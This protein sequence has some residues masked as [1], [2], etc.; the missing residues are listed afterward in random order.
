M[1]LN[2][3][4]LIYLFGLVIAKL[5]F[6]NE[7]TIRHIR[8]NGLQR[9]E[10]G[11]VYSYLPVKE[12]DLFTDDIGNSII[13][14]LYETGFFKDVRIEEQNKD[15]IIDVNERPII[16]GLDINGDSA[17]DHERL[18]KSLS[19]NG[20][21]NSLIFDQSTLDAAILS[22]KMEYYNRG[23][24]AVQIVPKVTELSRNRVNILIDIN[25]GGNAQIAQ[26][27]F[28]GNKHY[29]EGTLRGMMFLSM[30]N[31]MSWWYKDNQYSS[32]KLS[33]D[34]ETIKSFYLNNG[35]IDFKINSIQVQLSSNKK[36]VSINVNMN[37]GEQYRLGKTVVAG[38]VKDAD[39]G[40]LQRIVT[41][42][43]GQIINQEAL[44]RNADSIKLELGKLGYAF[45]SVTPIPEIVDGNIV[46]YT[47]MVDTGKKVSV[48]NII[49]SGNEKTRDIVIRREMRQQEAAIYNEEAIRRSKERLDSLGFF[50]MTDVSTSPVP[51]TVDQV[52]INVKTEE[53]STG[54][55]NIGAGYAQGQGIILNG[56]ISQ[57]NIF[58]SGKSVSLNASTSSLT[59]SVSLSFTDPYF[60][61]NG[62]S[63]GYDVYTMSQTPYKTGISPYK[64]DN[65]GVKMRTT[66]PLS[67]Y[68][69]TVMSVGFENN[70]VTLIGGFIP[71]RFVQFNEHYGDSVNEVS[72]S[73]GWA[74]NTTDN[75]LWPTRGANYNNTFDVTMPGIGAQYYRVQTAG[76]WF[77]PISQDFVWKTKGEASFIN[78]YGSSSLVPF[79]Q[80]FYEGGINSLRGFYMGSLGPRDTD[81]SSLGGT[82]WL[83][84]TNDLLFPMPFVKQDKTTR[85]N[86]F[87]DAGTLFGGSGFD[88]TPEQMFRASYGAGMTWVS[89]MGPIKLSY[90]IPLFAQPNDRIEKFQFLFGS[91]F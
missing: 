41:L 65:N 1:K 66:I 13:H 47:M 55:F 12:G 48:R 80:N 89:P 16:D 40:A 78:A 61:S 4:I 33:G 79:Y 36:K 38:D 23:M 43:R 20:L 29:S 53:N 74:R 87:A 35:Y 84:V 22:L 8:V 83:G 2:K 91:S 64:T 24:Y 60:L 56:G 88:L 39:L 25:E 81:G 46:N 67:E 86:L 44:V 75:M 58:G 10:M 14:R 63:L 72:Y 18:M 34:L 32:D 57:N 71:L 26:I 17:F 62:T 15:L 51:G 50:K 70:Q 49:I 90:A 85:L 73:I 82:R 5:A 27:N 76:T 69:R 54:S 9:I 31:M 77:F 68:D 7:F 6:A 59:R 3:K 52:D 45:A 21:A 42:R 11:T 37:E 30:G 28:V 19:G